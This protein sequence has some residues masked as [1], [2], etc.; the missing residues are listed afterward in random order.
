VKRTGRLE[1]EERDLV[2]DLYPSL[3]RFASVVSPPEDDPNDLVQEALLRTLRR[4]PLTD[5]DDPGAYLRRAVFNLASSRRRSLARQRI[6]LARLGP[7]GEVRAEHSWDVE[8]LLALPPRARAVLYLR[9]IE[10][11]PFDEIAEML[12]CSRVAARATASRARRRLRSLM[13]EEVRDG[14]A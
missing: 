5:L 4:G 2:A 7:P 12:G 13:S 6:A 1:A 11:R 14:T 10:G 3:R 9:I 8:E